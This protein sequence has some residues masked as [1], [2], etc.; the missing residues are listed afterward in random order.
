MMRHPFITKYLKTGK[1]S[2][3]VIEEFRKVLSWW[4][5]IKSTKLKGTTSDLFWI[6]HQF[7]FSFAAFFYLI[8]AC[9]WIILPLTA[10]FYFFISSMRLY[11]YCWRLS[12]NKY[13]ML[14]S[15]VIFSDASIFSAAIFILHTPFNSYSLQ[16]SNVLAELS[17]LEQNSG[18]F[19]VFK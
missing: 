9:S 18:N 14:F 3:E 19:L 15:D 12:Y 16:L 11:F 5:Y 17:K 10:S 1:L 4:I 6:H 7:T 2:G 8:L 13:K